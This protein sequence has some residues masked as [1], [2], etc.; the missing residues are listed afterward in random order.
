MS[1]KQRGWL[2]CYHIIFGALALFSSG[3]AFST[4]F[5]HINLLKGS[6]GVIMNIILVIFLIDYLVRLG[7][8]KNKKGFLVDNSFDML[9]LV[10]LHPIFA[11]F[12]FER[13]IRMVRY[14]HIFW[15]L[16]LDGKF[17]KSVHRF[18]YSTGFV[19]LL[20][21]SVVIVVL[22]A[23]LYSIVEKISLSNALWWAITTA[24]T[25]GYGDISPHTAIGKII[26]AIL[27]LGGIGFIGLLTSTITGFFTSDNTNIQ[28]NDLTLL[29]N[30]IDSLSKQVDHLQKQVS[31]LQK[32]PHKKKKS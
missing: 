13:V 21:A 22:S 8:S 11:I 9:G 28:D 4:F 32:K 24:T 23:L 29:L 14:Y 30:K 15:H 10:P 20:Y 7:L 19:Y 26:A 1:K 18:F 31:Q 5:T 2:I 27:M 12:R 16:G 3:L 17:T 6:I 25:V